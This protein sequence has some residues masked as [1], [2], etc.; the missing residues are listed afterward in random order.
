[1]PAIHLHFS[2]SPGPPMGDVLVDVV[3]MDD[4]ILH[5]LT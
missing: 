4:C 2:H 5:A 1:M 3:G